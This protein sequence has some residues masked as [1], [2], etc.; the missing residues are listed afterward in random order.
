MK[1]L[2]ILK[3][4]RQE[5]ICDEMITTYDEENKL[6]HITFLDSVYRGLTVT[7]DDDEFNVEMYYGMDLFCDFNGV[8]E[9]INFCLDTV[10]YDIF[11]EKAD[12]EFLDYVIEINIDAYLV[13]TN[14]DDFEVRLQTYAKQNNVSIEDIWKILSQLIWDLI[15][16]VT[17]RICPF[18]Q[19]D[20][21]TLV[22]DK[23]E[24]FIYESCENCFG[25]FKDG[26]QIM[27]PNSFFPANKEIFEKSNYR[28]LMQNR[29]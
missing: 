27:R 13:G 14:G 26:I 16:P 4:I 19:C 21:L 9:V 20:N 15:V 11:Y 2:D 24:K 8:M 3:A 6:I 18:C 12:L 7:G 23:N 28:I 22:V 10:D 17:D 1:L 5:E 25:F 29:T